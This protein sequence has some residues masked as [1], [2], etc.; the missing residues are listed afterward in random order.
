MK[1]QL[2]VRAARHGRSMEAELRA[3]VTDAAGAT[4]QPEITWQKL[5]VAASRRSAEWTSLKLIRRY[6]WVT[7]LDFDR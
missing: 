6:R 5:S 2:R 7:H 1:E 3:I 4:A